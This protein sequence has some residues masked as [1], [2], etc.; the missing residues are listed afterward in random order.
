MMMTMS[1]MSRSSVGPIEPRKGIFPLYKSPSQR[2]L[3]H[4]RKSRNVR[5]IK[6]ADGIISHNEV[7]SVLPPARR[8]PEV[9]LTLETAERYA[10][11]AGVAARIENLQVARL[12]VLADPLAIRP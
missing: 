1:R 2:Y 11:V 8:S 7:A 4:A 12:S 9:P 6:N 5:A 3:S 10:Y